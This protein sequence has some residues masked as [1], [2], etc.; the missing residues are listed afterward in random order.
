MQPL[1]YTNT[2]AAVLLVAGELLFVKRSTTDGLE[3]EFSG[4]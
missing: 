4:I 3:F 2:T 1:Q